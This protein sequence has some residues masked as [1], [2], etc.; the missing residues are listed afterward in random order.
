MRLYIVRHADP[1]YPN[2]TITEHGHAEARALADRLETEC[3]T[4]LHTSPMNRARETARYS[5]ERLGMSATVEEWAPELKI[6]RIPQPS[7]EPICAFCIPGHTVRENLPLPH[8]NDWHERAPLDDPGILAGVERVGAASDA[9]LAGYGYE[10]DGGIYRVKQPNKHRIAVVC[11]GG[12]GRT[13]LA[14]LL[15]IPVSL[16]WCGLWLAPSSVTIILFEER[17]PG[18]AVPKCLCMSDTSHLYKAGLPIQPRGLMA[19]RE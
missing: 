3:I 19:N 10:R 2:N 8:Q 9:F 15:A 11:H 12:L 16:A 4:H 13:W 6:P 18:T 5:E 7:A 17:A 1:D 14:H